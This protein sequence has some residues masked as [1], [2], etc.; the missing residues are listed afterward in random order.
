MFFSKSEETAISIPK[1]QLNLLLLGCGDG[2][3]STFHRQVRVAHGENIVEKEKKIFKSVIYANILEAVYQISL[4][5]LQEDEPFKDESLINVATEYAKKYCVITKNVNMFTDCERIF[6]FELWSKIKK[7]IKDENFDF[8]FEKFR[9]EC[10]LS[11]GMPFFFENIDR[12]NP[13]TYEVTEEDVIK[14][15]KKS[16][17]INELTISK[18]I[19]GLLHEIKLISV[20]GQRSERK[21]WPTSRKINGVLFLASL[22]DYNLLCYEDDLTNRM[23]ESIELFQE[24]IKQG[25][26]SDIP[27]F[28]IFNKKDRFLS[29]LLNGIALKEHFTEFKEENETYENTFQF[30]KKMY[31]QDCDKNVQIF[32]I[33]STNLEDTK[34]CFNGILEIIKK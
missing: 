12:L 30:I 26:F 10:H 13:N 15:R 18:R 22:S 11:D 16:I 34:N 5:S 27:I 9:N 8:Y 4:R 23:K 3:K 33:E 21:K 19:K 29:K 31:L 7:L 20:G 6:T 1:K 32:T 2:G 14:C 25:L 28:L 17:G 24:I